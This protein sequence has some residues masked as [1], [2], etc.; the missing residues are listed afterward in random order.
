MCTCVNIRGCACNT[1]QHTLQMCGE[2]CPFLCQFALCDSATHTAT[3]RTATHTA[4][5]CSNVDTCPPVARARTQTHARMRAHM[6]VHAHTIRTCV[7][8]HLSKRNLQKTF[9]YQR[10]KTHKRQ[11]RDIYRYTPAAFTKKPTKD[12]YIQTE[13]R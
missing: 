7:C 11:K 3:Q 1:L 6:H 8:M 2:T 9:I 5:H 13:K 10:K 4:T 12:K